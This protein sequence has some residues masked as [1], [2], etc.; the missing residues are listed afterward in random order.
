VQLKELVRGILGE[1][2]RALLTKLF[3]VVVVV[4]VEAKAWELLAIQHDPVHGAPEAP[5]F[6]RGQDAGLRGAVF[7]SAVAAALN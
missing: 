4:Q 1:R 2:G 6:I 5:G 7:V 3:N